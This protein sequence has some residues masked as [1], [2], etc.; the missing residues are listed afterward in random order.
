MSYNKEF[1]CDHCGLPS[2][3]LHP[4]PTGTGA[5]EFICQDCAVKEA[6]HS[7]ESVLRI[8]DR[9]GEC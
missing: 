5:S 8:P 7:A 6:I 9:E 1:I 4:I 2:I 3:G